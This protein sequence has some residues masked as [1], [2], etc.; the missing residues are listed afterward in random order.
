[1]S[2]PPNPSP[3]GPQDPRDL[4]TV[5]EVVTVYLADAK[6]GLAEAS[7][8]LRVV[9]LGLF[10]RE[11]GAQRPAELTP[12]AVKQ[13]IFAQ[14]Q[15]R[16]PHTR[17][18][19]NSAVQRCFNWAVE[20]RLLRENPVR[21][22]R[23]REE[24]QP[25]RDMKPAE[26]QA[27]LRASDPAFRR[28]LVALK[29]TGARPSE[30][31]RLAWSDIQWDRAVAV[32]PKHKTAKK[33][34]K[35]R[36]LVFPPPMMKL[37]AWLR[38]R[39]YTAAAA[40]LYAIL[41]SSPGRQARIREVVRKMR[42]QGF[43]YRQIYLARRRL[44]A[45]FRR[46]GGWAE[47]GYTVYC[48][49]ADAALPAVTTPADGLVFLNSKGSAWNKTSLGT[50]FKRLRRKL[51]L[52]AD[53]K[54]YGLR[55]AF[56]TDGVRKG[57]NLKALA[58]LAGHTTTAMIERVYCHVADDYEFLHSAAL[59]AVGGNGQGGAASPLP[60]PPPV[61]GPAISPATPP[62]PPIGPDV[63]AVL[64]AQ[65]QRLAGL[66]DLLTRKVL[67]L[68]KAPPAPPPRPAGKPR[69]AKLQP[70]ARIAYEA[71]QWAVSVN[72]TLAQATDFDI[73]RWLLTRPEYAG[74]LPPTPHSFRRQLNEA[75][76]YHDGCGKRAGR[77]K[78]FIGPGAGGDAASQGPTS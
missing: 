53:C 59:Q 72:P 32:L 71:A 20:M 10:S 57:V 24:T 18:Q 62:A 44:G 19:A 67:A 8:E 14:T 64:Q 21:G 63:A 49:P 17:A 65:E 37:L 22:L 36:V 75:R 76:R 28:F 61:P 77:R 7:Y 40:A 6:D 54:L 48:L 4:R 41:A 60:P 51:G 38:P 29:L 55:H 26:L 27:L 78:G 74:Q 16:S 68:D 11:F 25:G 35:P 30:L 45:T 12:W 52:P 23:L 2:A 33:T 1:M 66:F 34:G 47:H 9:R 5:A 56:I 70:A 50:K 42:A 46:V 43:T 58:A 31:S 73:F 69:P 15:W 3:T 39:P 13:W